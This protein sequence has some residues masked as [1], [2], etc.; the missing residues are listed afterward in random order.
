[1]TAI[2][3]ACGKTLERRD[4]FTICR[5]CKAMQTFLKKPVG[6][7]KAAGRGLEMLYNVLDIFLV[8]QIKLCQGI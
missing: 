7:V 1:M 3:R 2:F 4:S 5:S 6:D 8:D